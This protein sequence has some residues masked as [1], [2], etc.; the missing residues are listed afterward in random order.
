MGSESIICESIKVKI[1]KLKSITFFYNEEAL[2]PFYLQHYSWIDEIL[3]IVTP[4]H[5][6]TIAILEKDPRVTVKVVEFPN[7]LDDILKVT[8]LNEAIKDGKTIA[9]GS[10]L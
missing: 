7:G 6:K 5:D 1:M 9:H 4:G 2:V 8:L 10:L 3:A